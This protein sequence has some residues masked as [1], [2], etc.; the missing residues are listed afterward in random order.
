MKK[1]SIYFNIVYKGDYEFFLGYIGE[2]YIV[3]YLFFNIK[4]NTYIF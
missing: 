2:R 4:Y 1:D 3:K